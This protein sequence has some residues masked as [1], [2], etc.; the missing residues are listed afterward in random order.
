MLHPNL[1]SREAPK[2]NIH[3]KEINVGKVGPKGW[4]EKTWSRA[5]PG[6]DSDRPMSNKAQRKLERAA[7]KAAADRQAAHEVAMKQLA[8]SETRK[9]ERPAVAE[10]GKKR[11]LSDGAPALSSPT[12]A[13][14]K[15]LKGILK[16]KGPA[17]EATIASETSEEPAVAASS[18]VVSIIQPS[19][20]RNE[21]GTF[22]KGHMQALRSALETVGEVEFF[23]FVG[24]TLEL[25][26]VFVEAA[27]AKAALKRGAHLGVGAITLLQGP[28]EGAF[29][30]EQERKRE[31]HE[32]GRA[33]V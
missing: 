30:A 10:V 28:K 33:H 7:E 18:R 12:A 29:W 4:D 1:M 6:D 19:E 9:R 15:K 32:I 2:V 24:G 31:E 14:A 8:M 21:D 13:D 25:H 20:V 5:L 3:R 23:S 16:V 27:G 11:K 26:A 17:V 22:R